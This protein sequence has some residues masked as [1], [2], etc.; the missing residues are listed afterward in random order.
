MQTSVTC[1]LHHGSD[2]LF[3]KRNKDKRVD[4][5]R[6]NGIGGRLEPGENF[7]DAAIREVKEE[8]GYE[9]SPE[10]MK[11]AGVVKLEGGYQEDWVM[12]FFKVEV[13]TKE[14]PKG[15]SSEDGELI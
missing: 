14:I 13:S 6:L 9:V 12:C 4:P 15:T 11:L 3:I 7:L 8:T 10:E 1:F 2:Y 5:G